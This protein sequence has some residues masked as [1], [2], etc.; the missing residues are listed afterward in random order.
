M[1]VPNVADWQEGPT[2]VRHVHLRIERA[3]GSAQLRAHGV[4]QLRAG[5]GKREIEL[6]PRLKARGNQSSTRPATTRF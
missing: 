4:A 6:S 3:S 5:D 1:S 2:N